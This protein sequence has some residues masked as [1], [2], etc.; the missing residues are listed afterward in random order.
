VEPLVSAA[1]SP[2]RRELVANISLLFAELPLLERIPAAVSAGFSA[3]EAWWPFASAR[4]E[5]A[6]LAEFIDAV[7]AAGTSLT[8][9]NFFA[10]DMSAGE[11]GLVS[12]PDRQEEFV[13]NVECIA[14][15]AKRTG[16]SGF[17]ALYGQRQV[18]MDPGRQDAIAVD[19]LIRATRRLEPLGGTVL[20]EP[21]SRG[22]NGA[23][24]IETAAEGVAIVER[25]RRE[26]GLDNIAL[27]F[28]TFHLANN[29]EDLVGVVEEYGDLIGHVQLADTP[30][31]GA[32]GTGGID[33]DAVFDA[34]AR[35][36]YTGL[37][38]CEYVPGGPTGESL[39]W[40]EGSAFVELRGADRAAAR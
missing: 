4:P 34:L 28:D 7:A 32:P 17:N 33:F 16:A 15:I 20:V 23:Y 2:D 27:L 8:G 6:E 39:G 3:I 5:P 35:I 31:R 36:D 22:L 1:G 18:G 24:P 12:R 13:S 26:T 30:G 29:G 14:E 21:L 19:N 11:R 9:L 38:A 10:G 37:V 25:V 40:V